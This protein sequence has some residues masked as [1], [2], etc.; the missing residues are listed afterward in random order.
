ML[1]YAQREAYLIFMGLKMADSRC[2]ECEE[3]LY[4][5]TEN[6]EET[7]QFFEGQAKTRTTHDVCPHCGYE[8][9][10]TTSRPFKIR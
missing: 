3:R 9:I 10:V 8:K 6:D 5:I 1:T 7:S 2:P 4:T